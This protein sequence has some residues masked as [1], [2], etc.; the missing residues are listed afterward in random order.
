MRLERTAVADAQPVPLTSPKPERGPAANERVARSVLDEL[1]P[2]RL[3]ARDIRREKRRADRSQRPL[4]LVVFGVRSSRDRDDQFEALLDLLS[5]HTRETDSIGLL[6]DGRIGLLC[7]ETD[8]QGARALVLKV[9]RH[10]DHLVY[11]CSV[12]TYPHTLFDDL[13]SGDSVTDEVR[14]FV[15]AD[16]S[17]GYA[18]KR[19]FDIIVSLTMLIVLLPLLL[20]VAAAIKATSP[21]PVVFKQKRLGLQGQ[22]FDFYKFRSMVVDGDEG[23]HKK[24]I[25]AFIKNNATADGSDKDGSTPYKMRTDP[26]ITRVG[27][28][29]RKTSI[30]EL[31]QLF[32]VL[33]GDMSLVGPRPPIPYE[34]GHYQAWHL[35]R[36]TSVKPGLTGLWQVEGRGR[37]EFADMVRMDLRY[38][39]ECSLLLDVEILFRTVLVVF[40][41]YGAA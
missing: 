31:P 17:R 14:P 41:C 22:P 5:T 7:P 34:A 10:A 6:A 26:R 2:P 36:I 37:V 8:P 27:R 40:K 32:N 38:V 20:L 15:V 28:W 12:A 23:I 19:G 21:G 18:L 13:T 30:D 29:I 24:Y 3:F 33:R 9:A 16:S 4:S 39:R 1:L 11:E 35:R 25:E